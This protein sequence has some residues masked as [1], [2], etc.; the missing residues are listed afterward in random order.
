MAQA[1]KGV[2]KV[3]GETVER[4]VRYSATAAMAVPKQWAGLAS[5][6][7]ESDSTAIAKCFC[8]SAFCNER[9]VSEDALCVM[10]VLRVP[11]LRAQPEA[12]A[13]LLLD[14]RVCVCMCVCMCVRAYDGPARRSG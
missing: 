12:N 2:P 14:V 3:T 7:S 8:A 1:I 9:S 13:H 10:S 4:S 11:G 5:A 6:T